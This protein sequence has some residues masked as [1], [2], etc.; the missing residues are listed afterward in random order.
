MKSCLLRVFPSWIVVMS[1]KLLFSIPYSTM[2]WVEVAAFAFFWGL[3]RE[4]L[5]SPSKENTLWGIM[6][7]T[8]YGC[9]ATFIYDCGF[10]DKAIVIA[11]AAY[12]IRDIIKR[13]H[14]IGVRK[15]D[16]PKD[17]RFSLKMIYEVRRM[18]VFTYIVKSCQKKRQKRWGKNIS[19][20]PT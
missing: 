15:R 14:V 5:G 10:I 9:L 1:I 12:L 17:K 11:F 20:R 19:V 8:I 7:A 3:F 6:V 2:T 13:L 4:A 16:C 18:R